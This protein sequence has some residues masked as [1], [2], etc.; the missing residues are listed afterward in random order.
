M[1]R[2]YFIVIICVVG[3]VTRDGLDNHLGLKFQ[4]YIFL[5]SNMSRMGLGLTHHL[6]GLVSVFF[7][8]GEATRL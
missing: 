5:F 4:Q 6:V 1:W 8:R 2:S 7:P 3:I